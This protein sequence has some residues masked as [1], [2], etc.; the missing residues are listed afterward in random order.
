MKKLVLIGHAGAGK[1]TGAN[2]LADIL[3]CPAVHGDIIMFD[4]VAR[5]PDKTEA[6]FGERPGS[7]G[8]A[9][10]WRYLRDN[11]TIRNERALV[12]LTKDYVDQQVSD[13]IDAL[14]QPNKDNMFLHDK[15][16]VYKPKRNPEIVVFEWHAANHTSHWDNASYRGIVEADPEKRRQK[17]LKRIRESGYEREDVDVPQI[18]FSAHEP[19]YKKVAHMINL[20]PFKNNYDDT[21]KQSI[22]GIC[23][24]IILTRN[25]DGK[26]F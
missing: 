13:I 9:F 7:D 22:R 26:E 8:R 15:E 17:L 6:M 16:A 23:G 2:I 24:L 25:Q 11:T 1:S 18:R 5:F 12:E 3:D 20:P 10:T 14:T 19:G 21:F 4:A